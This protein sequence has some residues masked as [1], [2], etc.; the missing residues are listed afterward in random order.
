MKVIHF[1]SLTRFTH[2]DMHSFYEVF[3][4]NNTCV[5]WSKTT[6]YVLRFLNTSNRMYILSFFFSIN[7]FYFDGSWL[8]GNLCDFINYIKFYKLCIFT[9]YFYSKN[10][11]ISYFVN[12]S[13]M[14]C[15]NGHGVL[16][17]RIKVCRWHFKK[18]IYIFNW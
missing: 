14:S 16:N 10:N 7:A 8:H 11:L 9:F 5:Y 18:Y 17:L 4:E 12:S 3:R 1:A 6:L 15:L 13:I 2:F